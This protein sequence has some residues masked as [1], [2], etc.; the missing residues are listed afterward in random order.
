MH[1]SP[2]LTIS[3]ASMEEHNLTVNLSDGRI[4]IYPITGIPWI[5]TAS[6]E[7]QQN[8][9][10][11]EWDIYWDEID[12]GLTLEHILSPKPLIDF[13]EQKNPNWERLQEVLGNQQGE[14][15]GGKESLDNFLE[16]WTGILKGA[17]PDKLKAQYLEEKYG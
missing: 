15:K 12:D 13:T 10:V 3:S 6:P 2:E 5:S 14:K 11:T 9:T 17:D 4:I 7:K 1:S 8:F 16:E